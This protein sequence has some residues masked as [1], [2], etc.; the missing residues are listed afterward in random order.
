MLPA[1]GSKNCDLKVSVKYTPSLLTF[2][3]FGPL[4][5]FHQLAAAPRVN[6]LVSIGVE[7]EADPDQRTV[8][9]MVRM[10]GFLLWPL[11]RS[12]SLCGCRKEAV[13]VL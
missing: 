3:P 2:A 9:R 4:F 7:R 12:E 5:G 1:R 6:P 13:C 8:K 10:D 11:E